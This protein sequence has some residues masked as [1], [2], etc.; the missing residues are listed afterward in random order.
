MGN[1]QLNVTDPATW[2]QLPK[3][4]RESAVVEIQGLII[5]AVFEAGIANQL[6]S[7]RENG[8]NLQEWVLLIAEKTDTVVP[9]E[10]RKQM[11]EAVYWPS[12]FKLADSPPDNGS[13][14]FYLKLEL[15]KTKKL[16]GEIWGM[17]CMGGMAWLLDLSVTR[18]FEEKEEERIYQEKLAAEAAAKAEEEASVAARA[19]ADTD[20]APATPAPSDASA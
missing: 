5:K 8:I 12:M 7:M 16:N 2:M 17:L 4:T 13:S 10:I 14:P 18:F 3:S 6:V 15:A 9:D 1:E 11:G 19:V 20:P